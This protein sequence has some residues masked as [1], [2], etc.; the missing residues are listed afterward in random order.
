MSELPNVEHNLNRAN[1]ELAAQDGVVAQAVLHSGVYRIRYDQ[2]RGKLVVKWFY[3]LTRKRKA[4]DQK[5]EGAQKALTDHVQEQSRAEM[6]QQALKHDLE[7]IE[8]EHA[9]VLE[10]AERHGKAHTEL[11]ELYHSI[12]D[13]P[14][15]GFPDEDELEGRFN[16]KKSNYRAA[17]KRLRGIRKCV[18]EATL[19]EKGMEKI[20]FELTSALDETDA[21]F[22]LPEYCGLF[23]KRAVHIMEHVLRL[24][25]EMANDRADIDNR[26]ID[27]DHEYMLEAFKRAYT[28]LKDAVDLGSLGRDDITYAAET[29][30]SEVPGAQQANQRLLDIFKRYDEEDTKALVASSRRYEDARQTL[31]GIRQ[32]AFEVTVGFGA[33]A[34]AYHECCDRAEGFSND[35]VAECERAELPVFDEA[36]MPPPPSYDTAPSYDIAT[37]EQPN[38]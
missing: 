8:S 4:F 12:F 24:T 20:I 16:V 9:A 34:P 22:F 23:L 10:R 21:F 35:A 33:S 19:I 37:D 36:G 18:K 5:V 29:A 25:R 3:T 27:H 6:R 11:D 1:E 14:T 26:A 17:V 32:N 13:G 2:Q 31:H 7:K 28:A 30:M 38:R 15:P